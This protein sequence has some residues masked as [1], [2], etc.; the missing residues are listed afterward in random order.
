MFAERLKNAKVQAEPA[1]GNQIRPSLDSPLLQFPLDKAPKG[2]ALAW[3]HDFGVL[4]R[5]FRTGVDG[6]GAVAFSPNGQDLAV[7]RGDVVELCNLRDSAVTKTLR[8]HQMRGVFAVTFSPDRQYL[9]TT[10]ADSVVR[11][12]RVTTGDVALSIA[13]SSTYNH[14]NNAAFSPDGQ[15]LAVGDG[16]TIRRWALAAG[17]ETK[18]SGLVNY[19]YPTS[20]HAVSFSPDGLYLGGWV[21]VAN[22]RRIQQCFR[23][24]R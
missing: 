9:A 20:I 7:A 21:S 24:R 23:L 8:G 12:W 5:P 15:I 4:S 10:S 2:P 16:K 13:R 6:I 17:E 11:M 3:K 18:P 22:A 14:A 19:E 1:D